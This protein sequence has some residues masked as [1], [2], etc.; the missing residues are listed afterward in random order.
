MKSNNSAPEFN[1]GKLGLINYELIK[2]PNG[3]ISENWEF[4][5]GNKFYWFST[6]VNGRTAIAQESRYTGN[7]DA[8]C[9]NVVIPEHA[10]R[11]IVQIQNSWNKS[12]ITRSEIEE[13]NHSL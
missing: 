10:I 11:A 7:L 13:F 12:D 6:P 5:K 8:P 3:A 1:C 4:R 9:I 2:S